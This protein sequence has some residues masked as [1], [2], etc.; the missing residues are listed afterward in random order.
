MKRVLRFGVVGCGRIGVRHAQLLS[1]G[2]VESVELH[3]VCDLNE[4]RAEDFA[5][6]FHVRAYRNLSTMLEDPNIDVVVICTPSGLHADHAIQ[7]AVSGKHVVVEKP[8]AL[9]VE[10]ADR[11]IAACAE[12]Q[13]KLFVVKQNRFNIPVQRARQAIVEGRLGRLTLGTVR[14]RW[15]RP[16]SYYEQDEW[17]GTWA[18]DGGVLANQASH[19]IDAL[20]WM[21]GDVDSV[22]AIARTALANVEVEDTALAI[23]KFRSG[24]LGVIEATTAIRPRDLEGSLSLLGEFG[25]IEIAGTALNRLRTWEFVNATDFD[26]E[27]LDEFSENPPDVYGFGHKRYLEHVAQCIL[28][29]TQQLVDGFEGRRSLQLISAIYESIATGQ[30]VRLRFAAKESRLGRSV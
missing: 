13:V 4:D 25:S 28:E 26:Q 9:L 8:M 23:L 22:Y 7:V 21:M 24:A 3:A 15:C 2:E 27:S 30:E 12:N 17:R 11:M 20:E 16:N 19:H 14:V 1:S 10:D 29:N 18:L 6:R 5:E